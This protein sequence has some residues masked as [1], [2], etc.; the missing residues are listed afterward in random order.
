MRRKSQR[1][2]NFF[3]NVLK[4]EHQHLRSEFFTKNV[5][6]RHQIFTVFEE[7]NFRVVR[8]FLLSS[9]CVAWYHFYDNFKY[10]AIFK[11][12]F[13]ENLQRPFQRL[14]ILKRYEKFMNDDYGHF[15]KCDARR[16]QLNSS[17]K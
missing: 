14:K 10:G 9:V 11:A 3:E 6:L 8:T 5:F 12:V 16:G 4:H 15:G 13:H 17:R 2:D 7:E 1:S